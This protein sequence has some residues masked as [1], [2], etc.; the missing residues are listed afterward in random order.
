MIKR[1][2]STNSSMQL[3][4]Q[5]L[6]RRF[7][8]GSGSPPKES[9]IEEKNKNFEELMAQNVKLNHHLVQISQEIQLL[10]NLVADLSGQLEN[11]DPEVCS[12]Q[13]SSNNGR[14]GRTSLAMQRSCV[15]TTPKSLNAERM[16]VRTVT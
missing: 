4:I 9:Q 11:S 6:N 1:Q 5:F 8:E 7:Q 14:A 10:E 13:Q 15:L 16:F 2:V 3:Q 12:K